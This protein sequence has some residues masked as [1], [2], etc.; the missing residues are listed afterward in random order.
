MRVVVGPFAGYE[1]RSVESARCPRNV[2]VSE[3]MQQCVS[4]LW[5]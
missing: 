5:A 1:T 2:S 4:L 3:R